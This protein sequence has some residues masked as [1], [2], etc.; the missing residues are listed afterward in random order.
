MLFIWHPENAYESIEVTLSGIFASVFEG[1]FDW[2][3]SGFTF[4]AYVGSGSAAIE[5][6]HRQ[7]VDLVFVDMCM[8]GTLGYRSIVMGNQPIRLP[9]LRNP[10]E[11]D[12][13]RN[14]TFCT[15]PESA[16]DQYVSNNVHEQIDIPDEVFAE[17]ERRWR[18]GEPG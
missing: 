15:F 16:G 17:V 12:A 7:P 4:A 10:E 6:L 8:P 9:N 2:N 3:A 1:N 18:A 5:F 11:R 13:W 14:D